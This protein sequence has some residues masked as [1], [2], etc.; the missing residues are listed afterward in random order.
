M[1]N[2]L[3][4]AYRRLIFEESSGISCSLLKL[5]LTP[6]CWIYSLC[7]SVRNLAY[8]LKILKPQKVNIPV[9]V[10]VGNIAVGGTGKTPFTILLAKEFVSSFSVALLS[11]GY[12]SQ[13]EHLNT[14]LLL[15]FE[16]RQHYS[17]KFCGDEPCLLAE[18]LPKALIFVGKNRKKSAEIASKHGVE[19]IILDDGMQHRQ[20]SRDFDVIIIDANN[21][22]EKGSLLPLGLLRESPKSLKR[23]DLI[24]LNNIQNTEQFQ[25]ISGQVLKYTNAPIVGTRARFLGI[26]NLEGKPVQDLFGKKVGIFCGLGNPKNFV[27]TI[28]K[29][30]IEIVGEFFLGDHDTLDE[31]SL[32]KFALTCKEKKAEYI[33][34]TEKD[35]VK[36]KKNINIL[37][38]LAWVKIELEVCEGV[39]YWKEFVKKTTNL[40]NSKNTMCLKG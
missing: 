10:S 6:F 16:N 17:A 7:I 13:A 11:R 5:L 21:P 35:K 15:N 39:L 26:K 14:P 32:K 38:P 28:E 33:L 9:V 19:L 20:L 18:N 24:V 3:E 29:L 8:D 22:F 34:C 37:L 25:Q 36:L 30:N 23:G 12:K 27:N 2:K 40:V 31:N 1:Q 4:K